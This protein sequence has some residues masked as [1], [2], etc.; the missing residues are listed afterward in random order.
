[1]RVPR[2]TGNEERTWVT[3]IECITTDF[4]SPCASAA[5]SSEVN[6]KHGVDV[7][8]EWMVEVHRSI[9]TLD[10]YLLLLEDGAERLGRRGPGAAL[11]LEA[12]VVQRSFDGDDD[13]FK[14]NTQMD[15]L[16]ARYT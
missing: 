15:E 6:C 11:L 5:P 4:R 13:L 2:E 1:M 9:E 14:D 10:A 16:H 3:F 8:I 12:E 7:S